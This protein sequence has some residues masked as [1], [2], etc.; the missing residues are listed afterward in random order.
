[1]RVS[2]EHLCN[3]IKLLDQEVE[4]W[5]IEGECMEWAIAH[6]LLDARALLR[7]VR[8]TINSCEYCGPDL[9]S[10]IDA[11]IGEGKE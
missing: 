7:E 10:K 1:M 9:R 4:R 3:R 5:G 6:N 11:A 2:D 8:W